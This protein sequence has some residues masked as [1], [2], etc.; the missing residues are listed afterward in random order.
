MSILDFNL[1][2]HPCYAKTSDGFE[3][4]EFSCIAR[5]P[6][7]YSE[8]VLSSSVKRSPFFLFVLLFPSSFWSHH[9]IIILHIRVVPIFETTTTTNDD[10]PNDTYIHLQQF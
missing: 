10:D 5:I 3:Y 9:E 7:L 2:Q 8:Y 4:L 1:P 6:Q